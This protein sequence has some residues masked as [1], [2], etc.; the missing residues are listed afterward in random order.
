MFNFSFFFSNPTAIMIES[1]GEERMHKNNNVLC[2]AHQYRPLFDPIEKCQT[3][4]CLSSQNN[5]HNY[6]K[7]NRNDINDYIHQ[8]LIVNEPRIA[9]CKWTNINANAILSIKRFGVLLLLLSTFT[10]NSMAQVNVREPNHSSAHCIS[11]ESGTSTGSALNLHNH[12]ITK[13]GLFDSYNIFSPFSSGTTM[14]GTSIASANLTYFEEPDSELYFSHL[15][16]NETLGFVYIGGV[17]NIYQ[18]NLRLQL[19][20]RISMGPHEDSNECLISKGCMPNVAKPLSNYY[21]KALVVDP[22][23][24]WLISCGSLFQGTCT[25][26]SLNNVTNLVDQPIESVVANNATASTVAFIAPGPDPHK[27]VL[28]V[29]ATFTAGSYRSDLPIVSSRSLFENSKYRIYFLRAYSPPQSKT[30]YNPF[31]TD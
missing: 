2:H 17:N 15:V 23:H 11:L 20:E 18:L 4:D 13:R 31:S 12:S 9:N 28:Y 6:D 8:L 26:H 22:L 24:Q 16:I 14:S 30:K 1:N 10:A 25:A 7:D 27:Q 21:N 5:H 19:L 3:L 29:G